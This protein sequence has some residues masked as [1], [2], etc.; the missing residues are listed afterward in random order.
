MSKRKLRLVIG[1]VVSV[2][3]LLLL[4]YG[5]FVESS[6]ELT[7]VDVLLMIV[8][9]L[10]FLGGAIPSVYERFDHYRELAFLPIG[11]LGAIGLATGH[12]TE[13][14][15]FGTLLGVLSV[16][17]LLYRRYQSERGDSR[18]D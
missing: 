18:P 14:A 15:F 17:S 6:L 10:Y 12:E 9:G 3:T 11:T 13:L 1:V 7:D 16:L 5:L 4:V 2:A 8:F